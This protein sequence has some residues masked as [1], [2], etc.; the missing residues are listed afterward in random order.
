M[1]SDPF[2]A[3]AILFYLLL[4][5]VLLCELWRHGAACLRRRQVRRCRAALP[6]SW[7]AY[8]TQRQGYLDAEVHQGR[9][10]S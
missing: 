10:R 3:A 8:E 1:S 6:P 7:Q 4:V 2:T 9:H 5:P